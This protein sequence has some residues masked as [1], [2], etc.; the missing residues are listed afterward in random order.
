MLYSLVVS[1]LNHDIILFPKYCQLHYEHLPSI[2]MYMKLQTQEFSSESLYVHC[3]AVDVCF[4]LLFFSSFFFGGEAIDIKV[5]D[6]IYELMS[7]F[8][9]HDSAKS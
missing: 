2:Y 6:D 1:L 7:V 3:F 5:Y 8:S 9:S 4:L